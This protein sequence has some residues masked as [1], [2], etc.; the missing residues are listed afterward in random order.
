MALGRE[1]GLSPSDIV[2][3]GN[4]APL[5]QNGAEPPKFL[6]HLYCGQTAGCIKVSLGMEVRDGH[7]TSVA[8][9]ET[10]PRR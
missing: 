4:P 8:E 2:L 10:R 3:D 1:L 5:P 6:A 9:T 7:E